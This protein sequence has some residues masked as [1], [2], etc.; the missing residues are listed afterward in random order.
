VVNLTLRDVTS[1][2]VFRYG[3]TK[4][5]MSFE[6][7]LGY[8][9]ANAQQFYG[10]PNSSERAG[11]IKA[12][13]D[14]MLL[15]LSAYKHKVLLHPTVQVVETRVINPSIPIIIDDELG[16]VNFSLKTD[17]IRRRWMPHKLTK[18]TPLLCDY[19]NGYDVYVCNK[20]PNRP[21]LILKYG[22]QPYEF[23]QFNP[24]M[25]RIDQLHISANLMRTMT[26]AFHT[27]KLADLNFYQLS[28]KVYGY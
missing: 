15:H 2:A 7:F 1:D 27:A 25:R 24:W 28:K 18:A 21:I 6:E 14:Q 22:D 5:D 11:H 16:R 20:D 9:S 17:F 8:V 12:M 13:I 10:E 4:R 23:V 19:D 3:M 26:L